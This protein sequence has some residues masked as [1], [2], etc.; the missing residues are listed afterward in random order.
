MRKVAFLVGNDTFPKD[1]SIPPLRF[2]QNDARELAAVL[3]NP[4]TCGFETRLYLN[5]ASQEVL[6]DLDQISGELGQD[7]TLLFY[8]SGHGKLRQKNELCLVSNETTTKS[9]GATSIR[10]RL[11][12]E[13][14][15][16][17]FARRR[18]LILDCC[19]S[20]AIASIYKAVDSKSALDGLAN[21]FGTYILT[22]STSIELAEEREKDGH[23]VFTK[24]LIDCLR[25]GP[26]ERITINDLYEYAHARLRVSA[27]QTPLFWALQQEGTAVEI[28]NY[29]AKHE[30]ER[31]RKRERL[32]L[33][34]QVEL[35]RLIIPAAHARL[36][37]YVALG[38]LSVEQVE[39]AVALLNRDEARLVP[40]D[41]RYRDDLIRFTKG[42]ASFLEVFGARHIL[43]PEP[44][45]KPAEDEFSAPIA[46]PDAQG[47]NLPLTLSEPATIDQPVTPPEPAV[48]DQFNTPPEGDAISVTL[49]R[50]VEAGIVRR[51]FSY[52][53]SKAVVVEKIKRRAI[54][55]GEAHAPREGNLPPPPSAA[56]IP[57]PQPALAPQSFPAQADQPA[58]VPLRTLTGHTMTVVSVA[59]SPDGR[60][61]ASGSWD[62]TI[63]LWDSASGQ[64]LRKLTGHANSVFSVA[65]SPDGRTLA[66]GSWD[67]TIKLWDSA[68]GQLPRTLTGHTILVSSVAFSPDG[69]T[70]ASGSF[71][72]TIKLW[73]TSSG[74]LLRTVTGHTNYVLSVAFSLDGRTLASG[75][76]DNTIK[77]W[78]TASGELLR[79]LT[80][81]TK[82]VLSVAFSLDG[83]TLAS[84]SRDNTIKLWDSA[85]GKLLRTLTG[86][87]NSVF[88][89]AFSPDVRTLASGSDDNTI[90]LWD[91]ASGQLLRTLTGHTN[92]VRSVAFSPD[93][94]TLASGS[95]DYTI[96]LWEV[97]N[98]NEAGK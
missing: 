60:T 67:K 92:Y 21:S 56:S 31:Q 50:P 10:T 44:A 23:G 46:P 69:R 4:E 1:P 83:R 96:K 72:N 38:G 18:I 93:G 70:L 90:K 30:R 78:D 16:G 2:T 95:G 7:D 89:V 65:F 73:D 74:E 17:S 68:S 84:G 62:K 28:G 47:L 39:E 59:F 45:S 8:Y 41:R 61:L 11:V 91:T 19:H 29:Q 82:H 71:D 57:R 27:N 75:S 40:R 35:E 32:E 22:A 51:S 33:E 26:K 55:S 13:Y 34:R 52:G 3:E 48:V 49:K 80:G 58:S 79:T 94:R 63:K 14:L 87:T 53:R 24:A 12:L 77:L 36:G 54:A 5:R 25:E 20:G 42:D 15:Q 98:V 97:A 86:H 6:T 88:S 81:H 76:R 85:S 43:R 66:S 64:P 9:L 37:A